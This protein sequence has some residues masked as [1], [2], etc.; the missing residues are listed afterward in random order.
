MG[1]CTD[2]SLFSFISN[3]HKL[4]LFRP[5]AVSADRQELRK[6]DL[7]KSGTCAVQGGTVQ[8]P[9]AKGLGGCSDILRV[10]GLPPW[11]WQ[12]C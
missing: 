2:F 9:E 3:K 12:K 4:T 1:Y 8:I 6:L 5:S 10:M 7:R 11:Y